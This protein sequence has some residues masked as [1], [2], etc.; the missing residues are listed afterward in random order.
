MKI[1]EILTEF[2]LRKNHWEIDISTDA[3]QELG[4][5]LIS[6]VQ[7]AYAGTPQGSFVNSISNILPSD[8]AVLDFDP[9]PDVDSAVFYRGPRPGESWTGF[10]IQ[11]LGHDGTKA[12]K[13]HSLS[14]MVEMLNKSGW[15]IESSGAL[16]SVL[17]KRGCNV[18]QDPEILNSLFPGTGLE[19][20]NHTTY[21]RQLPDGGTITETVFGHPKVS[22]SEDIIAA[23]SNPDLRTMLAAVREEM[24]AV[25]DASMGS[26]EGDAN[27]AGLSRDYSA[28]LAIENVMKNNLKAIKNNVMDNNIFMYDYDGDIDEIAAI[29]VE[30]QGSVAHVKWLG[31]YN[32]RGGELYR[33]AMQEAKRRGATSAEVEAKWN[34]DGFYRKMGLDT[35]Q[36]GEYNPFTDSQLN[37]M[38][39]PLEEETLEELTGIKGIVNKLPKPRDSRFDPLGVDWHTVLNNYGFKSLGYGSFGVVWENPKL[40]YVL[41]VFSSKDSAYIDWISVAR[42]NKNNPHMPRFVSARLLTITPEVL[43]IRMEKLFPVIN[44]EKNVVFESA[45]LLQERYNPSEQIKSVGF[46]TDQRNLRYYCQTNPTWL[47]ALDIVKNFSNNSGYRLDFHNKNVMMRD[48]DTLVIT[49]PVYNRE[50]LAGR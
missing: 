4:D 5:D 19:M 6:L 25:D 13:E 38:A 11:G 12:S 22:L 7:T 50:D 37:K 49:D 24:E 28:L 31:S 27:Y 44:Q 29:H 30:M 39:G 36:Q 46:D 1:N 21:T 17:A 33:A 40:P 16:R 15:W 3:K 18:V 41:K 9:D 26:Q 32:G 10:K 42:Q 35:T 48:A 8:W 45:M 34:S 43:A 47:P 23:D 14:K 2:Q 20:V